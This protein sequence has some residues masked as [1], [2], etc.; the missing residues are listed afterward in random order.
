VARSAEISKVR[1]IGIAAHID[2]GKTTLTERILY[3]TGI[4]HRI[5]EVDNGNTQMDWMIQEQERGIT[6]TSAATTCFWR[7]HQINIIDTPGHV[8]FTVEVERSLRVL[9]GAI[10]VFCAVGGV[11]PQ[12]E[13]VWHQADK[14]HVPR[15]AFINKM[16]RVGADFHR[17]ID[18]MRKR[19]G[20]NP[21]LMQLPWGSEDR[22]RGVIDLLR[23][24]IILWDDESLGAEMERKPLPADM[25]TEALKAREKLLET[26]CEFDD[27]LTERYLEGKELPIPDVLAALRKGTLGNKIVPV[28]C[29]AAFRNKGVQPVLDGVV[30]LLPA[31]IDIPP[32]HGVHPETGKEESRKAGLDE[33]FAALAFKIQNDPYSGQLTYFRV[34]SGS[35]SA[36]KS[37]LNA[38]KNRK[39]RIQRLIRLHANKRE[40][41]K[42]IPAG[43]I[44]AIVGLRFTTTGDTLCDEKWPII[45]E[46]MEFPEPVV[47]IAIEPKSK[48]DEEKLNDSLKKLTIE[49]PTFRAKVSEETGQTIISGMGEL[50][51]EIIVDR[52]QRE[53]GVMANIGKPQVTYKETITLPV[54]AEGKYIK[55]IGG[56]GH[57]GHVILR[58]TPGA[59]GQGFR[60]TSE[61]SG[62][63]VPKQFIPAVEEGVCGAME[64]GV[65]GGYPVVDLAVALIGGSHNE[66]DSSEIAFKIAAS[67]GLKEALEKGESVL[68]EPM[69]SVEVI[70][71][72]DFMGDV[73]G[74]LNARRSKIAGMSMRGEIQII[75]A[76]VP[77]REMFG[78]ATILRSLTQGRAS[79]SMQFLHFD[80]MP[81]QIADGLVLKIRGYKDPSSDPE[82]NRRS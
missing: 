53:F 67:F 24:E 49:D 4:T 62:D 69:M 59:R 72:D 54:T 31:P 47:Y 42:D 77:L 61:V 43:H 14:Y 15:V 13:T 65:L 23:M 11:E 18:M 30:D 33:P 25:A 28:F 41:I 27:T 75:R 39:E 6:I 50:H 2:A 34:Y 71:P 35:I 70:V 55:Q 19:L 9:D 46:P 17:C 81:Q 36:G 64:S 44:A 45:Y 1:N 40:D 74:D 76:E 26:A 60:F 73:I 48:A 20:A 78:Y 66:V 82:S 38:S 5:G 58:I 37:V 7:D 52:L 79:Y 63:D 12:S 3:Y 68:L 21:V 56:R 51:L 32:M 8:D 10:A 57:Y 80:R 29:G 16:D 22:F